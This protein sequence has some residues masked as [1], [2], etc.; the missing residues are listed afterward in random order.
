MWQRLRSPSGPARRSANRAVPQC[1]TATAGSRTGSIL[2]VSREMEESDDAS[3]DSAEEQPLHPAIQGLK[4]ICR[5]N[6]IKYKTIER[7]IREG[8]QSLSQVAA[9]TT[10]TT[11]QCGGS[12]TPEVQEMLAEIVPRR[13]IPPP[14]VP[15]T[16][17]AWWVRKK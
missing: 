17:D 13:P 3:P 14:V 15:S 10:A 6:N 4:T 2:L 16:G 1:S 7:A 9:R 5:C 8:A 12:C 11:G